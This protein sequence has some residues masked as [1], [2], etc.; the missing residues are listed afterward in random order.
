MKE[1]PILFSEPM[2]RAIERGRKTQTRRVLRK[3]PP[4]EVTDIIRNGDDFV[5]AYPNRE[6]IRPYVFSANPLY[7]DPGDRL[8]VRETWRPFRGSFQHRAA[9]DCD[10]DPIDFVGGGWK[11]SI[12]M[13]RAACRLRLDLTHVRMER[14]QACTMSDAIREGT[15]DTYGDAVGMYGRQTLADRAAHHWDNHTRI[16]NFRWI[17]DRINGAR[18]YGWEKNPWVW[19]LGFRI[20]TP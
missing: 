9:L 20:A 19:V 17:W 16:E 11:P 7:G 14:L 1:R 10:G 4:A 15:P 18:G 2:L 5:A 6:A 8:W 3:Q 12:H 13:P